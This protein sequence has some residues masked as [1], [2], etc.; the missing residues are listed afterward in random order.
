MPSHL[1]PASCFDQGGVLDTGDRMSMSNY[2]T[3]DQNSDASMQEINEENGENAHDF[4]YT[5]T[6]DLGADSD[7]DQGESASG[8]AAIEAPGAAGV[9]A[10]GSPPTFDSVARRAAPLRDQAGPQRVASVGCFR[11]RGQAGQHHE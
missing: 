3:F 4:M 2:N 8:S 6:Y 9:S 1:L 5:G 10:A 11:L 7:A